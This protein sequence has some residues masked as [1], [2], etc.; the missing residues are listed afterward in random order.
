MY[1]YGPPHMA[2]KKQED[3][4][5]HTYGRYVR[6]QGV[7]LKT[8]ERRWT[9]G[10]SGEGGSGISVP[11]ARHD[12]DDDEW[13]HFRCSKIIGPVKEWIFGQKTIIWLSELSLG[14]SYLH[15]TLHLYPLERHESNYSSSKYRK[16]VE[17]TGF[18]N[19][20]MTTDL[21]E[22]KLWI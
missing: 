17:Q 11:T 19:L 6:I 2:G 7:A 10:R 22:R 21:T 13:Y 14:R 8:C 16:I 5:D 18:F 3:Q 15:F 4:L 20:G 1:S 12:D 9:I